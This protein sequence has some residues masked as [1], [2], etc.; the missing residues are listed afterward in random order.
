MASP[1]SNPSRQ[2]RDVS[3]TAGRASNSPASRASRTIS[4]DSTP[5]PRPAHAAQPECDAAA[6]GAFGGERHARGECGARADAGGGAAS[7]AAGALTSSPGPEQ[8]ES[9]K[10]KMPKKAAALLSVFASVKEYSHQPTRAVCLA[11]LKAT[12]EELQR[13]GPTEVQASSAALL[14]HHHLQYTLPTEMTYHALV[15]RMMQE[16]LRSSGRGAPIRVAIHAAAGGDLGQLLRAARVA[17]QSQPLPTV[18]VTESDL[19]PGQALSVFGIAADGN[20]LDAKGD[21]MAAGEQDVVLARNC[22][23]NHLCAYLTVRAMLRQLKPG[24][25]LIIAMLRQ[26]VRSRVA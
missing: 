9:G 5:S 25:R 26:Q 12:M 4:S 21:V 10:L 6:A 18:E 23:Y 24:G 14:Q 3:N 20:P 7:A 1:G 2:L 19:I 11:Q 17:P 16:L 15:E 8:P 22:W 13:M